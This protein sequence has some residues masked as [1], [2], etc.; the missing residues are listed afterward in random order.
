M[1]AGT[2][3]DG[4]DGSWFV[5]PDPDGT[6]PGRGAHLHPTAACLAL[7]ERKRAFA[8]ALRHDARER[9]ALSL[10]RLREHIAQNEDQNLTAPAPIK[11][12]STSS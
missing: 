6:A 11:N 5:S 4:R 1:V 9:G 2:D 3:A 8:R 10:E 12:G 7:A